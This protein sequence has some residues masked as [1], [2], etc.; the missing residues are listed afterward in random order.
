MLEKVDFHNNDLSRSTKDILHQLKSIF[1][2]IK[3]DL[4][5]PEFS[6]FVFN[7]KSSH[8]KL[9]LFKG[10]YVDY[11]LKVELIFFTGEAWTGE[12]THPQFVIDEVLSGQL[13]EQNFK[14]IHNKYQASTLLN[15]EQGNFR[16]IFDKDGHPHNV[17]ALNGPALVL[18]LSLGTCAVESIPRVL[19]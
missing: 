7:N 2:S 6:D 19:L 12:H 10:Q 5:I 15:R 18:C 16:A 3:Q 11:Y 8:G 9:E 14:K 1:F 4:I 17:I 13:Q